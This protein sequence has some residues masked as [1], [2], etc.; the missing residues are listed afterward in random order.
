MMENVMHMIDEKLKSLGIILPV[1]TKPVANYVPWVISGNLIYVSGQVPF[2]GGVITH[3]GTLG[4]TVT[5]DEAKAE[6]RICAINIIAHL[7]DACGGD[8]DKI[9]RIVKLTAFVASAP[10]FIEQPSIVNGASDLFVAV[11]GEAGRHA[12]SA[13]GV[14][15]LPLNA[16]VEIDA[17]AELI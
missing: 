3:P 6:A 2:V 15:A 16:A 7:R 4:N 9:K 11:F 14:A 12:R 5:L 10:N 13:V 17:I 1:S 8:L